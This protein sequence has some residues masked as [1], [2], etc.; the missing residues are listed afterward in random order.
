MGGG[1][2]A[3]LGS[4]YVALPV[5]SCRVIFLSNRAITAIPID[6]QEKVACLIVHW[7]MK[8]YTINPNP[9][10]CWDAKI[11]SFVVQEHS[12]RLLRLPEPQRYVK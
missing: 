7:S 11:A 6:L 8:P 2:A 5:L 1:N 12:I 3:V 10:H 9:N 4:P